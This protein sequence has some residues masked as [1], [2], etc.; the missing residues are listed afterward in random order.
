[1]TTTT[2]PAHATA[3]ARTITPRPLWERHQIFQEPAYADGLVLREDDDDESEGEPGI[4][5]P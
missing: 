1:M 2:P 4:I 3:P 5:T